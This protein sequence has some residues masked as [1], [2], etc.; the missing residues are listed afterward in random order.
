MTRR[1]RAAQLLERAKRGPTLSTIGSNLPPEAVAEFVRQ[2]SLWAETWIVPE[3]LALIPELRESL[4]NQEKAPPS[5]KAPR[6][7]GG[8]PSGRR[9]AALGAREPGADDQ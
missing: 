2:Y 4:T 5:E 8:P 3:I 9:P 6:A 1:S 7:W